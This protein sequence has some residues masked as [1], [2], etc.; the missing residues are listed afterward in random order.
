MMEASVQMCM[1]EIIVGVVLA[2]MM[3]PVTG[4][5]PR[6]ANIA[7][8]VVVSVCMWFCVGG[9]QSQRLCLGVNNEGQE[10]MFLQGLPTTG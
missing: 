3:D 9:G 5:L 4:Y 2:T 6:P 10:C 8:I 1:C 7:L